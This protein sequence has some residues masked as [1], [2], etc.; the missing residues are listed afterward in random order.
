MFQSIPTR[1]GGR[2]NTN[3]LKNKFEF[4]EKHPRN[5]YDKKCEEKL[6]LFG[7][8]QFGIQSIVVLSNLV[9]PGTKS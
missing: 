9:K 8:G 1:P 4:L 2:S 3:E 5:S 6:G 7:S